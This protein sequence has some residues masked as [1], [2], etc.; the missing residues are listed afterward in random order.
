MAKRPEEPAVY[1][2]EKRSETKEVNPKAKSFGP[3]S[4]K[5]IEKLIQKG[6]IPSELATA[7]IMEKSENNAPH[8]KKEIVDGAIKEHLQLLFSPEYFDK[9]KL[10]CE[11][12][13]YLIDHKEE[14]Y[15][16]IAE[17][18]AKTFRASKDLIDSKLEAALVE[19]NPFDLTAQRSTEEQE[20][21]LP[22]LDLSP[23]E[24]RILFVL[25]QLLARNSERY[26]QHSSDYYLGNYE[27]GMVKIESM[28]LETAR[29]IISPH[30]LYKTYHG[31]RDYGA[32]NSKFVLETLLSLAK[33]QFLVT[34]SIPKTDKKTGKKTYDKLRT[35]QPLF[36]IAI[37]NSDLTEKEHIDI[38][39]SKDFVEGNGCRFV[40][41][42]SPIF[43]NNIRERYIEYPEDIH[44]RI[45]STKAAGA[46]GRLPQCV[47][48]FRD[49]LF[50]EKQL[51]RYSIERDEETL[52]QV[53]GL[54]T[55]A[56]SGK[57]QRIQ[58][59]L[60]KC[61]D[62]FKE[63]GLLKTVEKTAGSKGQSKYVIQ[64]DKEFK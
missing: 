17:Q 8:D 1:D 64:I 18:E 14:I 12:T 19:L 47:N 61:F 40:F 29:L 23:A 5:D 35:L 26:N 6:G 45:A 28:E 53:L 46:K 7:W 32:D 36:M 59:R 55:E 15:A 22:R 58:E 63:L 60:Q 25:N 24:D 33:K 13:Q 16:I 20:V 30:E 37:L 41:K 27:P 56:K 52:I 43:T 49:L 21:H 4:T 42:F 51:K 54:T 10:S 9:L 31:R 2:T 11:F 38:N 3:F 39:N 34:F 44:L 48:L 62:I 50:R 57:R